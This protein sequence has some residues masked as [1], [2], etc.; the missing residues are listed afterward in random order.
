MSFVKTA[1]KSA[2]T[3]TTK[4]K[5]AITGARGTVGREVV[6]HC[7]KEGHQTVQINRSE[8]E[9]DGTPNSEMRTA[10][11][12]TDYDAT[13][14]AFKGCDAVIHLAA[15]PNPLG[16][17]DWQVHQNN[18]NSAFN[19]LRAAAELGIKRVAYASSVNAI[20]LAYSQ[21]PLRLPYFP[22][23]EDYPTSPSDSYA[24]AKLEAETAA[25]AFPHW[26]PGMKIACLRIHEVESRPAVLQE[27][28]ENWHDAG[29]KQ[30]WGWVNPEATARACLLGVTSA[31]R[32]EGCQVFNIVAPD[33]TLEAPSADLAARYYPDT[34]LRGDWGTNRAFWTSEKAERLLGWTH[35]EKE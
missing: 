24:L 14:A 31:D 34:E 26:F 7:A 16:K 29:V 33:T 10:D 11:A 9:H 23:D 12:A 30:L 21:Q 8:Q 17:P 15:L 1:V 4:M 28:R 25:R 3:P 22:I 2:F 27:H 19:G 6:K 5:I 20:G 35:H 13:V 18:V 32:F